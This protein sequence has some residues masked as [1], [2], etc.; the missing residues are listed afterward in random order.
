MEKYIQKTQTTERTA[1]YKMYRMWKYRE[2][3]HIRSK[4]R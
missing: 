1:T 3:P 4:M 2:F